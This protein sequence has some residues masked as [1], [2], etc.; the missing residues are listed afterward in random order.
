MRFHW[1]GR[2]KWQPFAVLITGFCLVF[3]GPPSASA[4]TAYLPSIGPAPMRFEPTTDPSALAKWDPLLLPAG[5][6]IASA[7]E[8]NSSKPAAETTTNATETNAPETVAKAI[9]PPETNRVPTPIS[10]PAEVATASNPPPATLPAPAN[11]DA[12]SDASSDYF[13]QPVQSVDLSTPVTPQILAE[14]FKPRQGGK[15]SSAASVV[16]PL[17]ITFIPPTAPAPVQSRATY[18]VE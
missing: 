2:L 18:K 12:A 9:T 6:Q 3:A 7:A 17:N 15:N 1:I 16:V 5:Q 4:L 10:A 8:T 14:Y 13:V 11:P